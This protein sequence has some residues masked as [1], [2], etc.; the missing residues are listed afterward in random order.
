MN[1]TRNASYLRV[2]VLNPNLDTINS[3]EITLNDFQTEDVNC[4]GV[5]RSM[6]SQFGYAM[7]QV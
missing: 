4:S 7:L 6:H 1:G 5:L 2:W 3:N